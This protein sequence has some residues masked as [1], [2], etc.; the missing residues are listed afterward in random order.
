MIEP[1][2]NPALSPKNLGCTNRIFACND[3]LEENR[4]TSML[5]GNDSVGALRQP[6]RK[7]QNNNMHHSS[8]HRTQSSGWHV[9]LFTTQEYE[10]YV[11]SY[12]A[13]HDQN[14]WYGERG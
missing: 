1:A 7:L 4:F 2:Y 3:P 6:T 5:I 11:Q 12:H 13:S 10:N 9:Y 8:R 14:W